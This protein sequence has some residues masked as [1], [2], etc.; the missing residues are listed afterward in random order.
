M[1]LE[2]ILIAVGL[3][4]LLLS[5]DI[6][7]RGAV[8]L[9]AALKIPALL[10][11]LTVVAFGTSAP[12]LIVTIQAVAGDSDGL[13]LGNIIGSNIANILL[14][15]GLPAI[16]YPISANVRGLR[17]HL[18]V[19][20]IATAMFAGAAYIYGEINLPIGAALFITLV[21]YIGYV[22]LRASHG[23]NEPVL[24][25][26]DDYLSKAGLSAKTI[27][28]LIL[29][30]IGLPMGAHLLVTNG[31]AL[32]TS[33]G[34]RDEII[35]LTIIAFGTSL[36]ELATVAAAAVHKK[37]DVAIG[38]IVGSNIFNLLAVGA[39]AGFAGSAT[40]DPASLAYD[41]PVMIAASVVLAAFILSKR[42]IGRIPG[43]IMFAA[44]VA[45][46]LSIAGMIG[47]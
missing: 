25:D 10:I 22:W 12:E 23:G 17:R 18:V 31:A 24:D 44:Y 40:F 29:G 32:A 46:I 30:L 43:I 5:G 13:A 8:G 9:A 42:N 3:A 34:V 36:P 33:F 6:L 16:I 28:F 41:I 39:A 35:G 37:S 1:D 2:F 19:M 47:N 4:V 27:I 38:G 45:F 14:V 11:S 7:V 15:L 20:I 21:A 26:V